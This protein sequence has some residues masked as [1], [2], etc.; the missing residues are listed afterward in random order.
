MK[1]LI[2]REEFWLLDKLIK[3]FKDITIVFLV[4]GVILGKSIIISAGMASG[5]F[6]IILVIVNSIFHYY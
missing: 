3:I 2:Y 4:I 6:F 1:K 5:I